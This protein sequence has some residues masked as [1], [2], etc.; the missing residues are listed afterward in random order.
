MRHFA[1]YGAHIESD[2]PL[3]GL[4]EP[5]GK[6]A[7]KV[8]FNSGCIHHVV[9]NRLNE[10]KLPVGWKNVICTGGE[11]PVFRLEGVG[12]FHLCRQES[13]IC[14]TLL[15]GT[16]METVRYWLMHYILPVYLLL[17]SRFDFLHG[18]AIDVNGKAVAFLADA[19]GG[20]STLADFFVKR[21]HALLTD[22]HLG[23]L[24]ELGF[25]AVPSVP[26]VRPYRQFEDLGNPVEH[27]ASQP[28]P[29]RA[30]YLLELGDWPMQVMPLAALPAAAELARNRRLIVS[31][32]FSELAKTR[33]SRLAAL[34]NSV[35]IARL[36][37][38]RDL[39]R[40][41]EVYETV[42]AHLGDLHDSL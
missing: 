26:F 38:P 42:S 10:D 9:E 25:L 20:K 28:L 7:V 5:A 14:C 1:A 32:K 33:F 29:L 35:P 6:P 17:D 36:R 8:K 39:S 3:A 41:P 30:M 34:T 4:P 22:D 24:L 12:E 40:L 18:S 11:N 37:V 21:G 23:I 27:F 16:P 31:N 13:R 19:M 2:F 15:P